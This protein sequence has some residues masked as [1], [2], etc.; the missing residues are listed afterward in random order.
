MKLLKHTCVLFLFSL[1]T[2]AF[3]QNTITSKEK[4]NTIE[5]IKTL[6]DLNYVFEGKTQHINTSIDSLNQTG[7]YNTIADYKAFAQA[8]TDD[9]VGITNDKHFLVTYNPELIKSRRTRS[10]Q[11]DEVQD[12]EAEDE[13]IDW[14]LWYA[15]KE[16]FGFE[17]IEIL[18]GNIGYVKLN[19]W[20]PLDWAKPTID[21]AM[22]FV[23][24][25]DA[26]II[27]LTENQGGYSPTESYLGS[28][29][30]DE[31]PL[32]WMSSYDRPTGVTSTDSTF[33][34][35]GG[36]RY[37]NR[38]VYILVSENTFSLAEKFAYSMKH[39][40]KA[41][42]IGQASAGAAHA[43]NFLEVDDKYMIQIP[44]M[45]NIHPV[46][47]TDWEGTGVIP[48]IS[49]SKDEALTVAY[50]QALEVQIE[51]AREANYQTLLKRYDKIKAEI[52]N[53]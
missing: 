8:L 36:D 11:P 25:T 17:K 53:R 3:S 7:K 35:V 38:P 39:F 44:V 50:L 29:F 31:A 27:D 45:Y 5:S 13:E 32:A 23:S 21:A 12:D 22:R 30:F 33:Q 26:L 1:P 34:D 37:L 18:D 2:V 15:K 43:I 28:Y 6:I 16:N 46:T 10:D 47:N 51:I 24:H 41:T 40:G 4:D 52:T 20:H 14:N 42:I 48:H 9:L 49:T 19:F